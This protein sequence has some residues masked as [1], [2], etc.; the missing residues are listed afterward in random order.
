MLILL[1][2]GLSA[3]MLDNS[4]GFA[5]TE[6]PYFNEQ[7]VKMN[8]IKS[9]VGSFQYKKTGETIKNSKFI[10]RYEFDEKG[11]LVYS[12]ETKLIGTIVDTVVLYYE[13]DDKNNLSVVRQKDDK[14]FFA[15][16]YIYDDKNRLVK[17]EYYR[18]I[19][20]TTNNVSNPS[21]ERSIFIN[22]ERYEYQENTAM[23][24]KTYY[25]NYNFPYLDEYIYTDKLGL[26]TKRE[27]VVRTTSSLTTIEY[28]YNEKGWVSKE[29]NFSATNANNNKEVTFNYDKQGNL[30][31]K[32]IYKNGVHVQDIQLI[33]NTK[34]GILSYTLTRDVATNY[35]TIL[36]F[37][38]IN[39]F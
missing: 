15:T 1:P 23:L 24:K 19:D 20:T 18:D 34:T 29:K 36:K 25:N 11:H 22:S 39:Y 26:V 2:L 21:F 14:G 31:D 3:Q 9:L 17:E 27:K 8:R 35:I 6:L 38:K 7:F 4:K 13:Y 10:Y 33:Y 32:Q 12:L 37:D 28:E 30:I 16:K 5:F